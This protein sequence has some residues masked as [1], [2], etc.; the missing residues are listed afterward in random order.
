M[1]NDSATITGLVNSPNGNLTFNLYNDNQCTAAG[2]ILGPL[3]VPV[4]AN[5]TY[6]TTNTMDLKALLAGGNTDGHYNWQV[7]YTGD[8]HGNADIIGA[9]GVEDFT[10]DN[11]P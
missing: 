9:C 4:N 1:P 5:G 3:T 8:T 6:D 7:S 10:V 2:L 11:G